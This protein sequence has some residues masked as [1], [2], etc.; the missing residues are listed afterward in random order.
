MS[1][2]AYKR[3]ISHTE[4]PRQIERR[5]LAQVTSELETQYLAFDRAERRLERLQLL[6]DGLRHTLQKNQMVWSAFKMDLV[7]GANGLSPELKASLISLSLWVE[8]HT[9][10][11]L[12][13]GKQVKPLVDIN[14]SIVDGL[15]GRQ[16]ETAAE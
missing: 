7:D 1:V 10:G 12:A 6:A 2:T 3:T 13:G 5:I 8:S 9:Q 4:A 11:V 16:L 14:R 15:S